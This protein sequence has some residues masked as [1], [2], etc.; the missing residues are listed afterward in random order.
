MFILPFKTINKIQLNVSKIFFR[1]IKQVRIM[2]NDTK[3]VVSLLSAVSPICQ[4]RVFFQDSLWS[5]SW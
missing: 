1:M 3:K 2:T 5:T 4:N